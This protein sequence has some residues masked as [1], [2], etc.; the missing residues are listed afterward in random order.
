M[1]RRVAAETK[2]EIIRLRAHADT[3]RAATAKLKAEPE[4]E[5]AKI[6]MLQVTL[7]TVE[8]QIEDDEATLRDLEDVIRENC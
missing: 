7:A 5:V 8:K 6:K 3:L 1:M 2:A 4:P